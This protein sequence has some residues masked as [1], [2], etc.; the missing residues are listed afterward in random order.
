MVVAP[1]VVA[2][3]R[4]LVTADTVRLEIAP[5]YDFLAQVEAFFARLI[6]QQAREWLDP[7][8]IV[9]GIFEYGSRARQLLGL[10]EGQESTI[11]ALGEVFTST[12]N[13]AR[14]V[15]RGA[16][17]I[18]SLALVAVVA[19]L[20]VRASPRM[21]TGQ[22]LTEF[23]LDWYTLILLALVAGLVITVLVQSR[24]TSELGK[25]PTPA[26]TS[27]ERLRVEPRSNAKTPAQT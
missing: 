1:G 22:V 4:T 25:Q 17:V 12:R 8:Q 7:R 6:S 13:R 21:W 2:Y 19:L 26:L 23:N 18:A 10:V 27:L 24:Q 5:A 11:L 20:F 15:A 3:V 9:T 16:K 14:S